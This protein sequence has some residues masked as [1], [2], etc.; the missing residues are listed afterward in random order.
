MVPPGT[1]THLQRTADAVFATPASN[2]DFTTIVMGPSL[3]RDHMMD[4]YGDALSAALAGL[5][6]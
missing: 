4:A 2:S 6:E 3:V 5:D 1:I